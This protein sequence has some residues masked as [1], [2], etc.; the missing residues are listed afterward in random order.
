[1]AMNEFLSMLCLRT[2][3][4]LYFVPKFIILYYVGFLYYVQ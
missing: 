1:M 2:R 3:S 4:S